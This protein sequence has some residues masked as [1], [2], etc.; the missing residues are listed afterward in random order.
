MPLCARALRPP[1]LRADSAHTPLRTPG[2]ICLV[3]CLVEPAALAKPSPPTNQLFLTLLSERMVLSVSHA[4]PRTSGYL[5]THTAISISLRQRANVTVVVPNTNP[6]IPPHNT[7]SGS[8]L[9]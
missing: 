8:V 9:T 3:R 2:L 6:N 5:Y 7:A 1:P 4:V